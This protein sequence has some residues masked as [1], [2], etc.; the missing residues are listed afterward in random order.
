MVTFFDF[1]LSEGGGG[2]SELEESSLG[3]GALGH[4]AVFRVF[5]TAA[6]TQ[7]SYTGQASI[8]HDTIAPIQIW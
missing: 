1:F 3:A 5:S 8:A 7:L 6:H 4:L 2:E